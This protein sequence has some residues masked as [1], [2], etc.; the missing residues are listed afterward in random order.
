[1]WIS[2]LLQTINIQLYT[3]LYFHEYKFISYEL[4]V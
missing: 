3:F 1:L 2:F 4:L